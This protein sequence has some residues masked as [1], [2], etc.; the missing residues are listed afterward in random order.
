ME[1]SGRTA[2]LLEARKQ[3]ASAWDGHIGR[4]D[5]LIAGALATA[6][7]TV[8]MYVARVLGIVKVDLPLLLGTFVRPA[9][10]GARPIGLIPHLSNTAFVI[11]AM[12]ASGFRVMRQ[13]PSAAGGMLL[14][15]VHYL[16]SVAAMYGIGRLNRR[17]MDRGDPDRLERSG[18]VL[19]PGAFGQ[20]YGRQA[21]PLLF[22]GHLAYGAVIGWWLGRRS[23]CGGGTGHRA[24]PP[25]LPT[26]RSDAVSLVSV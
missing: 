1:L 8:P 16:T 14:A 5:V 4:G 6:T 22:A 10:Q 25:S 24:W 18:R 21:P 20:R 9:G 23:G 11:P 12:Y 19:A 3:Q 15:L 2:E 13:R 7:I 26:R 17:A